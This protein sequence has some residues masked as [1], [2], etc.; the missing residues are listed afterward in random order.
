MP[1]EMSLKHVRDLVSALVVA[2]VVAQKLK[3][4]RHE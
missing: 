2:V 3:S 1:V 4:I